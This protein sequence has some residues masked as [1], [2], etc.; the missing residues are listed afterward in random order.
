[1]GR[2]KKIF[3]VLSLCFALTLIIPL[4]TPMTVYATEAGG[5]NEGGGNE[6]GGSGAYGQENTT[7][8]TGNAVQDILRDGRFQGALS[9]I[10]KITDFI[11]IWFI[12]IISLVSFFIISAALLKNAC[13]GAYCA[14]SKFW[15]KVAD[16]HQKTEAINL[17][18][19]KNFFAGGQG[20]MNTSAGGVK[21]FLLGLVP[22]IKA[23]TDFEDADI[24]PKAYFMKA[25][26]QM[27][28]CVVIGIFIYNGYYRD[29]AATVG[30]MGSVLIERTLN[31]VNPDSF[32]NKLFNTT[33]W[34]KFPWDK[35]KSRAGQWRQ[36]VSEELKSIVASNCTDITSSGQKSTVVTNIAQKV[37]AVMG[38]LSQYEEATD[39]Y[40]WNI[41][42]VSGYMSTRLGANE[43]DFY[44][45]ESGNV[46]VKLEITMQSIVPSTTAID[47]NNS[48]AFVNFTLKRVVDDNTAGGTNVKLDGWGQVGGKNLTLTSDT[49]SI[50]SG[51]NGIDVVDG[52]YQFTQEIKV[53]LS[54]FTENTT[55][56]W[57]V[58]DRR[59]ICA[60]GIE[61]G[62]IKIMAGSKV[63]T[64]NVTEKG[65]PFCV[66]QA[67]GGDKY[68]LYL[69]VTQ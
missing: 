44:E 28:A 7:A 69:Q 52:Q 46:I 63:P 42:G 16:A 9:S 38:Q 35:D 6:G 27:I 29:T 39:G 57:K 48:A 20:I 5:G 50:S 67:T 13:A 64:S 36:K 31:S 55:A 8:D 19:V 25:I 18:G 11:D 4:T 68:T 22:N 23:F 47:L 59:N 37:D 43:C 49:Y 15:D 34:P 45:D 21:D 26:P 54:T 65:L 12:R 32:V 33:G 30:E 62:N 58:V 24:E 41:S 60:T 14:N 3:S 66:I 2:L 17:A 53:P 10:S 1:M 40:M 61:D 51:A 56:G